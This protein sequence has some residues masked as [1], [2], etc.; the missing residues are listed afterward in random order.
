MSYAIA[1]RGLGG[2]NNRVSSLCRRQTLTRAIK[3]LRAV[4]RGQ[5]WQKTE[6]K[7]DTVN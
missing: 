3:V 1:D 7:K 5:S 6:R 2:I 4:H